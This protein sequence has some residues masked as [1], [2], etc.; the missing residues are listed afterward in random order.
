MPQYLAFQQPHQHLPPTY[1]DRA[2]HS[3]LPFDPSE[4]SYLEP[5]LDIDPGKKLNYFNSLSSSPVSTQSVLS[6]YS[7]SVG[8]SPLSAFDSIPTPTL[9]EPLS[10]FF[11]PPGQSTQAP[12]ESSALSFANSGAMQTEAW[13][14]TGRLTPRSVDRFSHQRESSRSSMGST[15]PISPFPHNA[16]NPHIA[17]NDS[18]GDAFHSLAGAD[19]LSSHY[20][21]APKQFP[22]VTHD[23]FFTALPA[24]GPVNGS[25]MPAYQYMAAASKRRNDRNPLAPSEQPTGQ[26]RSHPVSVASSIASDS[27]A[28]PAGDPEEDRKNNTGETNFFDPLGYLWSPPR[29]PS[30]DEAAMP[31][32]VPKLDRTMTDAYTDELYSPNFT[33]TSSSS[34]Q[35]STSP[36]SDLFHQ[37]LQAANQHLSAVSGSPASAASRD[38]SPFRTHSPLAPMPLHEFPTSVGPS[39]MRFGSAQQ[40]R[41][42]NK[43]MRDAQAV[44]QQ[45][46][47]SAADTS[48]PQ[49]ISPKDAVLEFHD[50]EGDANFPLFPTQQNNSQNNN[51][52]F[53][54]EAINKAA[55]A[56]SQQVF[57]GLPMDT[58]TL[59]SFLNTSMPATMQVPQQFPFV[60]PRRPHSAVP[61]ASN[62]SAA[63]TRL[64]SVETGAT[65]SVHSGTPQRP[66]DTSAHGGTYTCTYHGCTL[67]FDTPALLQKHKREGHRQAHGVG[68]ARRPDGMG[69]TSSL[70]NTQAGPH[71]CDRINPSTNKP[72]GTVFSRPYDLTRHEDTIHNARKQK[73]RCDLCTDEKTFSRA[74]ALTRHYRVCHP[75]VEFPGK[76]RRRGGHSG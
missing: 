29:S 19:D 73:V 9:T 57:G 22:G 41:E 76:H 4:L 43:A 52:G 65:E 40:M 51:H 32:Q 72:C 53:N 66:A 55:A 64:G 49:T 36:T 67:R 46:A 16:A 7:K 33:I 13:M 38:R 56:H 47:R 11:P 71:R 59:N 50:P 74:D 2:H 61:S 12:P 48:T 23:S 39:P 14:P 37:R 28:T 6:Q 20:Q 18:V 17:V 63:T 75:D 44:Q 25:S 24:Y 68:G 31:S 42:Q 10:L 27:P 34:G 58:N 1:Y 26:G 70:Y 54:A 15:G 62:P 30:P 5:D 69:M 8:S 45:I 3:A 35:Q 21:L 60:A